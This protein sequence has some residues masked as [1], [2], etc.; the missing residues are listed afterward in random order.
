M[1]TTISL[2]MIVRNEAPIIER[3]LAG[4]KA[5][6]NE[7]IVVDTGSTDGTQDLA[8]AMGAKVFNFPWINDFAAARNYSFSLASGDWILWLDADDVLPAQTVEAGKALKTQYLPTC[9]EDMIMAPYNYAHDEKGKCIMTLTRERFLRRAAQPIWTGRIHETCATQPKG[10]KRTVC[11]DFIVDHF[12]PKANY[13][14]KATRNLEI[15]ESYLDVQTCSNH[16]RFLYGGELGCS[17]R[18]AE[19]IEV[20]KLYLTSHPAGQRDIFDEKYTVHIKLAETYRLL[21]KYQACL[22]EGLVAIAWDPAR[23][24]GYG[25]AAM[26]CYDSG[27]Y[28]A[29]FALFLA[30]AACKK[31]VHG[32]LVFDSFYSPVIHDMIKECKAKIAE[33]VLTPT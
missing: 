30:C 22:E 12:P 4:A 16:E 20:Y 15:F 32:G 25:V 14:R 21:K 17:D 31:P 1:S 7:L 27:N 19:A 2:C 33:K 13:D 3:V 9:T 23:G 5:F 11:Q 26:A 6:C 24:E 8:R 10:D 29:A 18:H 28:A